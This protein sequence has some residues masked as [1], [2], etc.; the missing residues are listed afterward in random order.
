MTDT[1]PSLHPLTISNGISKRTATL[2]NHLSLSFLEQEEK[3]KDLFS[4]QRL[5]SPDGSR[6]GLHLQ[7]HPTRWRRLAKPVRTRML[8]TMSMRKRMTPTPNQSERRIGS[9]ESPS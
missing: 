4:Q 6:L 3:S 1:C 9:I 2:R 7:R 8:R 5:S